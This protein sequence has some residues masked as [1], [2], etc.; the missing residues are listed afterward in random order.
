MPDAITSAI[1]KF[2]YHN[3]TPTYLAVDDRSPHRAGAGAHE[4][5]VLIPKASSVSQEFRNLVAQGRTLSLSHSLLPPIPEKQNH[6]R[7]YFIWRLVSFGDSFLDSE[8]ERVRTSNEQI[9]FNRGLVYNTG[10]ENLSL[11]YEVRD[12]CI[13]RSHVYPGQNWLPPLGAFRSNTHFFTGLKKLEVKAA[14]GYPNFLFGDLFANSSLTQLKLFGFSF[15]LNQ[16]HVD[17]MPLDLN[18]GSNINHLELSGSFSSSFFVNMRQLYRANKIEHLSMRSTTSDGPLIT[19]DESSINRELAEAIFSKEFEYLKHL[20]LQGFNL[21]QDKQITSQLSRFL[22]ERCGSLQTLSLQHISLRLPQEQDAFLAFVGELNM[23][24][25]KNLY[26]AFNDCR[27]AILPQ[28][29]RANLGEL[30]ELDIRGNLFSA[31][32]DVAAIRT[33]AFRNLRVLN[34]ED[35]YLGG[36]ATLERL[37]T[38]PAGICPS[39]LKIIDP[40]VTADDTNLLNHTYSSVKAPWLALEVERLNTVAYESLFDTDWDYQD[41]IRAE[42]EER[43]QWMY[44]EDSSCPDFRIFA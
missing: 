13:D 1:S 33:G 41:R 8:I 35:M 24:R 28:V 40:S 10:L 6:M 32:E 2:M 4:G 21:F 31:T 11:D 14:S 30:E 5:D 39:G 9:L 16:L 44:R 3:A 38:L 19:E 22:S 23:P 25:L 17:R 26:L 34:L 29:V 7:Q 36:Y 20:D 37:L 43:R 12:T 27:P 18:V 42:E 15:N